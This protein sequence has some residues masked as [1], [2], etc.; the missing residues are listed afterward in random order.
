MHLVLWE[1]ITF[2]YKRVFR[3]IL[4][5]ITGV[6]FIPVIFRVTFSQDNSTKFPRVV[7]TK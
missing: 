6:D 4:F 2:L 1:N 5:D 3:Y 7:P